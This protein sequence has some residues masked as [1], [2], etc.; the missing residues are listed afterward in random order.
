VTILVVFLAAGILASV[1][2]LATY[3]MAT[4]VGASGAIFGVFG[5]LLASAIWSVR[6]R[7]NLTIPL[8]AVNR[9]APAAIL[10]VVYNFVNDNLGSAAELTGLLTGL[11]CGAFLARGVWERKAPARR[12]AYAMAATLVIA[13]LGALPLRGITDVKPEIERTLAA[14]DRTAGTYQQAA[15]KF[16]RNRMTAEALAQVIDRTI[17]PELK[18]TDERLKALEGVPKEHEPLVANAEEYVRLRSASWRLRAEWL[19]KAGREALRGTESAQYRAN[20]K[21]IAQAEESERA[22]LDVLAKIRP[23]SESRISN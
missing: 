5:L 16:R 14:E 21:T 3:P 1:V 9:L 20:S 6:H 10:F 15:E 13:V 4:G 17:I 7:S 2:N 8:I 11:V 22:A 23:A 18:V 19:R 12:A